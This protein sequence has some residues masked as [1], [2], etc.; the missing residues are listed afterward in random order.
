MKRVCVLYAG[1]ILSMYAFKFVSDMF[2]TKVLVIRL[3]IYILYSINDIYNKLNSVKNSKSVLYYIYI[4]YKI[5]I[6]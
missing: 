2:D 5:W 3:Y 6:Y 1:V 4:I